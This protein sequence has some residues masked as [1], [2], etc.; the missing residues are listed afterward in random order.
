MFDKSPW[1]CLEPCLLIPVLLIPGRLLILLIWR[2]AV[3]DLI[4]SGEAAVSWSILRRYSPKARGGKGHYH[5][6]FCLWVIYKKQGWLHKGWR[7]QGQGL[8]KGCMHKGWL[9]RSET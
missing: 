8:H 2:D 5:K 1:R 6:V 7:R 4:I 3:I 9:H